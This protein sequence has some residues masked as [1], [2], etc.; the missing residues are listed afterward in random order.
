[1]SDSSG[2]V[3]GISV[4]TVPWHKD[5]A[6]HAHDSRWLA[7]AHKATVAA[8]ARELERD[9]ILGPHNKGR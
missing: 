6:K 5:E 3:K 1:M 9:M 2:K 4:P 8:E 7:S